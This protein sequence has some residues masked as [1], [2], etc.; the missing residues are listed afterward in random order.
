MN[1]VS[2]PPEILR[3]PFTVKENVSLIERESARGV[4]IQVD[5]SKTYACACFDNVTDYN[6]FKYNPLLN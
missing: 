1:S 6:N 5:P 2:T 3:F 4:M